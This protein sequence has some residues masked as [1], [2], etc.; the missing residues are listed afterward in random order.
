[1]GSSELTKLCWFDLSWCFLV[2]KQTFWL[3]WLLWDL[4]AE[5]D[6]LLDYFSQLGLHFLSQ[7]VNSNLNSD[8]QVVQDNRIIVKV[9]RLSSW[10]EWEKYTTPNFWQQMR[11][12]S[13]TSP[14]CHA[15]EQE[16]K[17]RILNQILRSTSEINQSGRRELVWKSSTSTKL[18]IKNL[19]QRLSII[20]CFSQIP[21][22]LRHSWVFRDN[23]H[24]SL[25]I[26]PFYLFKFSQ[27]PTLLHCQSQ[28]KNQL[29]DISI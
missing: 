13:T 22:I 3:K 23:F 27:I 19:P 29:V 15:N 28:I 26:R 18:K 24:R 14:T 5:C 12:A 8:L 10:E 21:W 17:A 9:W 1:M 20:R 2:Q 7:S 6:G 16:A 25:W 11:A 4:E